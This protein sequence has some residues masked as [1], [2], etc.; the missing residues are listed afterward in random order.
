MSGITRRKFVAGTVA[1]VAAPI[2]LSPMPAFAAEHEVE[3]LNKGEAGT[4]VFE[5]ALLRI[6]S[7]DAVKFVPTDPGHNAESIRD[8]APEGAELFKGAMGKEV[9]VTFTVPGVYGIKCLPHL[10]MG[11][12]AL[13]VVDDP[14]PNLEAA[15]AVRNPPK[16][17][18]RFDALFAE[19][20]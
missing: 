7:G 11:M 10:A 20:E 19:L 6:A 5:P 9:S 18:E 2:A 13:V 4:M 17:K 8:M 16:A 3:M 15:K 14:S 12:I 1:M